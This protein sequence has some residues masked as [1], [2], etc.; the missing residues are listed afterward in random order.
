MNQNKSKDMTPEESKASLGF[1][2]ALI[3]GMLKQKHSA[4]SQEVDG[5]KDNEDPQ[6]DLELDKK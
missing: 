2:T 6:P 1:S 3:E 4:M 5:I